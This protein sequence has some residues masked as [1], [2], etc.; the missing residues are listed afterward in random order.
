[1]GWHIAYVV[2]KK[3][4]RVLKVG[5]ILLDGLFIVSKRY[6]PTSKSKFKSI[7]TKKNNLYAFKILSNIFFNLINLKNYL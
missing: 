4:K 2:D 6:K 3:G 7:N 5:L 1:M